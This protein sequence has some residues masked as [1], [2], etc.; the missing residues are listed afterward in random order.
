M[1]YTADPV[2]EN[3]LFVSDVGDSLRDSS[4]SSVRQILP[5]LS[6]AVRGVPANTMRNMLAS[7]TSRVVGPIISVNPLLS[8]L[9]KPQYVGPDQLPLYVFASIPGTSIS[10]EATTSAIQKHRPHDI[11]H[12]VTPDDIPRLPEVIHHYY[13]DTHTWHVADALGFNARLF[14]VIECPPST[15]DPF[16]WMHQKGYAKI[17]SVCPPADS[18]HSL[19]TLDGSRIHY[20]AYQLGRWAIS[21]LAQAYDLFRQAHPWH[22]KTGT[23]LPLPFEEWVRRYS[24]G[25][26]RLLEE[27]RLIAERLVTFTKREFKIENFLKREISTNA[28][29]PRNISMRNWLSLVIMGPFVNAIERVA[30]H[31]TY[32]VKHL[33]PAARL[34]KMQSLLDH[35]TIIEIDQSRYDKH[36]GYQFMRDVESRFLLDP[37]PPDPLYSV[38]VQQLRHNSGVSRYGIRYTIRG[39]R[40]SGDTPTSIN[41]TEDH[42]VAGFCVFAAIV[43]AMRV[44]CE[45]DDK[46]GAFTG[47]PPAARAHIRSYYLAL[48]FEAKTIIYDRPHGFTFCG[49]HYTTSFGRLES[50]CDVVRTINKFPTTTSDKPAPYLAFAKAL[51][52]L[53]TDRHTPLVGPLSYALVRYWKPRI[54]LSRFADILY[55]MRADLPWFIRMADITPE[56]F[57]AAADD[58]EPPDPPAWA[59]DLTSTMTGLSPTQQ[60]LIET[61][62]SAFQ[63]GYPVRP[64][65]LR[66]PPDPVWL[67]VETDSSPFF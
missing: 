6:N 23:L 46:I 13:Y 29:V 28:T 7:V 30:V 58:H 2:K 49:R 34:A 62:W 17:F 63:F 66:T 52:Y 18:P 10:T 38:G 14:I 26:R 11:W 27:C 1:L 48:G 33:D 5:N 35:P 21:P 32:M 9:D 24:R 54:D 55:D 42:G 44:I 65:Q 56:R 4:I 45:G 25:A 36:I 59:R 15:Y 12:I 3:L 40:A 39:T 57:L 64:V 60:R 53:H 47:L 50:T 16:A 19:A 20:H 22:P 41:N 31:A 61:D 67:S 51:C 37:F 43:E 8:R